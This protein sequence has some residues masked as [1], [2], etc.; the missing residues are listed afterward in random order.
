M[1]NLLYNTQHALQTCSVKLKLNKKR[2]NMQTTQNTAKKV[3]KAS[4][5]RTLIANAKAQ[6]ANLTV[7]QQKAIV[8]QQI[9]AQNLLSKQLANV[10]TNNN[11]DKAVA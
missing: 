5:V 4:I 11:W 8:V 3:T 2:K 9:I 1:F 7:Q 6:H 10:Y